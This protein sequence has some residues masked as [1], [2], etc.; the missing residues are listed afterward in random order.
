MSEEIISAQAWGEQ[1]T[2]IFTCRSGNRVLLRRI[3]KEALLMTGR[4]PQALAMRVLDTFSEIKGADAMK[5]VSDADARNNIGNLPALVNATLIAGIVEP[6]VVLENAN[7]ANNEINV[8]QIPDGDRLDIYREL[9]ANSPGQTVATE[10][11]EVALSGV[12]NLFQESES[13]VSVDAGGHSA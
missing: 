11:G 2:Y 4:V 9:S 13:P 8:S 12:E 3:D 6:R 10:A 7:P 5:A 1:S